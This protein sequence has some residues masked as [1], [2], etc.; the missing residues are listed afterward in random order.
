M[1][2]QK[3]HSLCGHQVQYSIYL[4]GPKCESVLHHGKS[5]EI[6]CETENHLRTSAEVTV[7]SLTQDFRDFSHERNVQEKLVFDMSPK[8]VSKIE[9][10]GR[11]QNCTLESSF[12]AVQFAHD[13]SSRIVIYVRYFPRSHPRLA[14][15]STRTASSA[16][17]RDSGCSVPAGSPIRPASS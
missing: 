3:N 10:S 2:P 8:L 13:S 11:S 6:F 5:G 1:F 14:A 7:Q 16:S 12:A 9:A 15:V 17:G 4:I